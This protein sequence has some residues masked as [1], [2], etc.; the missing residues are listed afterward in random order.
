MTTITKDEWLK[1][2]EEAGQRDLTEND[3]SS[4]TAA[5][6]AVMI[7]VTRN[8]AARRLQLLET[9]GKVTRTTKVCRGS[10]GRTFRTVA[11]RLL[12]DPA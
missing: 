7:G 8:T 12:V 3:P 2:L 11:F 9:A 4:L 10:D 5:E 1:A 6:F